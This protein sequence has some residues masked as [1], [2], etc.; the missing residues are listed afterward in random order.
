MANK[1]MHI[2]L[3]LLVIRKMQTK[4]TV[5]YHFMPTA[6]SEKIS[7]NVGE[8]VEKLKLLYICW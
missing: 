8:D 5:R 6:D 3:K 7:K 4:I 1:H 2:S